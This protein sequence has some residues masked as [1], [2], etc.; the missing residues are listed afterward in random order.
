[1]VEVQ[2]VVRAA[3][4]NL[5]V[6]ADLGGPCVGGLCVGGPCARGGLCVLDLGVTS[7][8]F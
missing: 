3:G 1:M 4:A 8:T 5:A 6:R 2:E 7:L